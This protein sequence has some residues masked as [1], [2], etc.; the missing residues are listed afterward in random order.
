[1]ETFF[2]RRPSSRFYFTYINLFSR[3][4]SGK[5]DWYDLA[6][7]KTDAYD[8]RGDK[9]EVGLKAKNYNDPLNVMKKYIKE[10]EKLHNAKA[11][12]LLHS[13]VKPLFPILTQPPIHVA[14]HHKKK[15]KKSSKSKKHKKEKSKKRLRSPSPSETRKSDEQIQKMLRLRAERLKR[16]EVERNRTKLLLAKYNHTD[17]KEAD[18]EKI[19]KLSRASLEPTAIEPVKVKQFN[20]EIAKQNYED[21]RRY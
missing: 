12:A 16:E 20:P 14:R 19:R 1:M 3:C 13:K 17:V 6:P 4:I 10:T 21:A 11:N 2:F 8:D 18:D 9:L 15:S 7:K 5:R